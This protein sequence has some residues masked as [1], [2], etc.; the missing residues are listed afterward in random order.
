MIKVS[1]K[2][3]IIKITGH[4]GYNDFGKDIVC[5][6]VSSIV[7]TTVNIIMNIDNNSI[8]YVD[9]GNTIIIEKLVSNNIID[10]ILNTMI[11]LLKD[12]EKQYKNNIKVE[13]EE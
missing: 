13:S 8:S 9:D 7:L 4:A 1:N 11:E 10:I 6:S 2:N 5:A 12:L 3:N